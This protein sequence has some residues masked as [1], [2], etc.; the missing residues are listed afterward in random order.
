MALL[1]RRLFPH[2]FASLVSRG[3]EARVS[4]PSLCSVRFASP[5]LETPIAAAH[6]ALSPEKFCDEVVAKLSEVPLL[7]RQSNRD[8]LAVQVA[9][10]QGL[11]CSP[12]QVVKMYKFSPNLVYCS[13]DV[14]RKKIDF[15]SGLGIKRRL[16]YVLRSQPSIL[17][18]SIENLRSRVDYLRSLGL[19][20]RNISVAIGNAP[21]L[22]C[23]SL[24]SKIP[25][26]QD[27]LGTYGINQAGVLHMIIHSPSVVGLSLETIS[28]K[29]SAIEEF[30]FNREQAIS[31]ARKYPFLLSCQIEGDGRLRHRCK[32]LVKT[33]G[34]RKEDIVSFPS[35][36]GFSFK[37]R[38]LFRYELAH[39]IGLAMEPRTYIKMTEIKFAALLG[40]TRA[41]LTA[42]STKF[43]ED[44]VLV[45]PK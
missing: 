25:M 6:T 15:L 20:E 9:I 42:M 34:I 27:F 14:M 1:L 32:F 7:Q 26:L 17:S 44:G 18:L 41:E 4:L 31:I 36:L 13:E 5:S 19:T 40:I 35:F 37:H 8:K 2:S 22:I 21:A 3:I 11:G 12:D 45:L 23:Y 43:V 33:L 29:L 38:L 24:Q 39:K 28:K 16:G 10:L 30:G